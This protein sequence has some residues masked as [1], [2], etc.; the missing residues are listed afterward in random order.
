LTVQ[1]QGPY[2]LAGA[3]F[4]GLVAYEMANQLQA[5]GAKIGLLAL[6]DTVNLAFYRS[7]PF[8]RSIRYQWTQFFLRLSH[9]AECLWDA[10]PLAQKLNLLVTPLQTRGNQFLWRTGYAL[11]RS[12]G[13][14]I[15]A[16]LQDHLKLFAFAAKRYHPRPY[17]GRVTLFRAAK[18]DSQYGS[19]PKLG[20]AEVAKEGVDVHEVPGDHISI[21]DDPGV[22]VLAEKLR[23]CID[24]ARS[25]KAVSEALQSSCDVAPPTTIPFTRMP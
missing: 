4:G 13:Y 5:R 12:M 18:H 7:L 8:P 25:A 16:C 19:D 20:W 24:R 22:G 6:F 21:L 23:S 15:P 11:F 14:P 1:P 2:Y 17:S 3:S 9:Y 10:S